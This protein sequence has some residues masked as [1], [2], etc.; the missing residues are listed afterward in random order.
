M[1]RNI[2]RENNLDLLREIETLLIT[3]SYQ[4]D[5]ILL[6]LLPYYAWSVSYGENLK[7]EVQENLR[8]LSLKNGDILP[9]ILSRTQKITRYFRLFNQRL[10]SPILRVRPEDRLCLKILQ[11]LHLSHQQTKKIP[12]AIIDG[13]FASWFPHSSY[14]A[15]YLIPSSIQQGL[16]YLPILFHEFGHI[17]YAYHRYEM[18]D[19]VEILQEEIADLI[20]PSSQRDDV[21]AQKKDLKR[22]LI[23]ETWYEWTQEIFCDAIGLIIGG[24]AFLNAFSM[25]LQMSGRG[26]YYI[27]PVNL[28]HQTHP[29]TWLRIQLLANRVRQ[30]G[31]NMN[32]EKLEKNW[33]CIAETMGIVE[34]Y[35]GYYEPDFLPLIQETIDDMLIE[36]EPYRFSEKKMNFQDNQ[37]K[38]ISPVHVLNQAWYEFKKNPEAYPMWEKKVISRFLQDG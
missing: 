6:E 24:Q 10:I 15:I 11:W 17:L 36:A 37:I 35:Y 29:I 5:L 14:P 23:V 27:N 19:L 33:K 13:E 8:Y 9:D 16:L 1:L 22:R 38:F 28:E 7:N 31:D 34:D 25:Y 32:A 20:E 4:K 30:M 3:L 21:Y 26:A 18:D 2:L 12:L